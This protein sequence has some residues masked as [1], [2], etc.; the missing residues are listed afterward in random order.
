[1]YMSI[2]SRHLFP[3]DWSV[4]RKERRRKVK[5]NCNPCACYFDEGE[6]EQH[7]R[8]ET[9]ANHETNSPATV[10]VQTLSGMA[11]TVWARKPAFVLPSAPYWMLVSA[12]VLGFHLKRRACIGLMHAMRRCEFALE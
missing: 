6:L 10:R 3:F 4:G 11:H 2:Q 1:M 8:L 9:G 5:L 7:M 12:M